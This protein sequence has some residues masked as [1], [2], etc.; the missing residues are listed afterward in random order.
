MALQIIGVG[1]EVNFDVSASNPPWMDANEDGILNLPSKRSRTP[2]QPDQGPAAVRRSHRFEENLQQLEDMG[3][4]QVYGAEL[5]RFMLQRHG[6][7]LENC[8]EGLTAL[9]TPPLE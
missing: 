2:V 7:M 4:L 3:L 9:G 1:P 5:C 8:I 6:N